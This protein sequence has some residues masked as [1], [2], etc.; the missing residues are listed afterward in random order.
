MG[1]TIIFLMVFEAVH[2]VDVRTYHPPIDNYYSTTKQE[3]SQ[4]FLQNFCKKSPG[5]AKKPHFRSFFITF[6]KNDALQG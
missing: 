1:F 2:L 3:K 5:R 6:W 4:A